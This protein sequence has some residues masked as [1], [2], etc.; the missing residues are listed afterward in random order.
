MCRFV[1]PNLTQ[2]GQYFY[3]I[4]FLFFLALQ[5]SVGY[6]LLVHEVSW[7]HTMTRHS[8]WD[9]SCTS[10]QLVA[11]TSTWQHTQQKNIHALGGSRTHDHS[12]RAVVDLR[13]RPR[14]HWDRHKPD[15]KWGKLDKN[16]LNS[17][18]EDFCCKLANKMRQGPSGF[19]NVFQVY[20]NMFRQIVAIFRGS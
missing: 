20:P 16:N 18:T 7:S 4:L 2:A 5:P 3:F 13:L 6:G 10:D 17:W 8:R 1:I 11:E 14:S 15:N 12:R 9:S 19:I